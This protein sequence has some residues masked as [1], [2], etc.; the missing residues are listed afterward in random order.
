MFIGMWISSQCESRTIHIARTVVVKLI[1]SARVADRCCT[2]RRVIHDLK[3][4]PQ[5]IPIMGHVRRQRWALLVTIATKRKKIALLKGHNFEYEALWIQKELMYY[6]KGNVLSFH[7]M[8]WSSKFGSEESS[9][10]SIFLVLYEFWT[11]NK[12]YSVYFIY[13]L[14][15][16]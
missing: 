12:L 6:E 13:I 7:L 2:H 8:S 5:Y 4:Y 9:Q 14:L 15:N 16:T 3:G 10:H 11:M 1:A